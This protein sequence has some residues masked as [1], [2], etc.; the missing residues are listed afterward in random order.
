MR[1]YIIQKPL[2]NNSD[3]W[4]W[5]FPHTYTWM[6]FQQNNTNCYCHLTKHLVLFRLC[7]IKHLFHNQTNQKGTGQKNKWFCKFYFTMASFNLFY[8]KRR[9]ESSNDVFLIS[10]LS[11]ALWSF[12]SNVQDLFW[13]TKLLVRWMVSNKSFIYKPANGDSTSTAQKSK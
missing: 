9:A 3:W 13:P 12:Y 11:P 6:L 8:G 7:N 4:L 2:D 5:D 10:L 1:I